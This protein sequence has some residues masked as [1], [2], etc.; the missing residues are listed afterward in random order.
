MYYTNGH[1]FEPRDVRTTVERLMLLLSDAGAQGTLNS[2]SQSGLITAAHGRALP[3]YRGRYELVRLSLKSEALQ[4]PDLAEAYLFFLA[5][6]ENQPGGIARLLTGHSLII[7]ETNAEPLGSSRHS[8]NGHDGAVSGESAGEDE[9]RLIDLTSENKILDYVRFFCAF[10]AGREGPF[11][12]LDSAQDLADGGSDELLAQ[13][14]DLVVERLRQTLDWPQ[15]PVAL[16]DE[17]VERFLEAPEDA[18]AHFA[19]E[20]RKKM[21]RPLGHLISPRLTRALGDTR[22]RSATPKGKS[23]QMPLR[24]RSGTDRPSSPQISASRPMA[25]SRCW[26]TTCFCLSTSR[27]G[28]SIRPRAFYSEH[29]K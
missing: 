3:F 2:F 4:T 5:T 17:D 9:P 12:P 10:V 15:M 29:K 11:L 8:G 26:A 7:H 18:R 23:S 16:E 14:Y 24:G 27:P 28:G 19:E 21:R 20:A 22:L 13:S 1:W 6:P 25:W